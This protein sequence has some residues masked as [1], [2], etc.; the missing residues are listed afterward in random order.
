MAVGA[1]QISVYSFSSSSSPSLLPFRPHSLLG[2]IPSVFPRPPSFPHSSPPSLPP[3]RPNSLLPF[4][5]SLPPSFPP[6]HPPSFRPSSLLITIT[7]LLPPSLPP[8]HPHSPS[9]T[10][11]SFP[12]SPPPFF[13]V[14]KSRLKQDSVQKTDSALSW[15]YSHLSISAMFGPTHPT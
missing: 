1:P 6:S 13:F 15:F 8:S 2:S 11:P 14:F 4:P 7:P 9:V 10:P 5:A 12:F 3:S